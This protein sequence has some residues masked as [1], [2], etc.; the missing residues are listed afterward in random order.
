MDV[1]RQRS[2]A[3]GV[4]VEWIEADATQFRTSEPF[5][6]AI[7]LCEGGVGL[8][9]HGED[10]EAH[11]MAIF[12]NI[13]ASL[14]PNA[15]FVLTALN[16]YSVIRQL[17]DENIQAGS[18]DPISMMSAYADEWELP[19]G[20]K[21]VNIRE[22]LF[23]A[24][25]VTRMLRDAGFVVDNVYGGTAGHWAQRFLSLDEVEAMFIGRKAG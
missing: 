21:Q 24:P 15:P 9:E 6:A 18:F 20:T 23:I 13:A 14:K 4:D 1:A 3:A 16:G 5:D 19:E 22:R 12:R 7:C 11:D 2:A 8:I 10:A 17:K 25:E